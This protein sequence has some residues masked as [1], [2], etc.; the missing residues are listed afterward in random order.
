MRQ[1]LHGQVG[2]G[3]MIMSG[4][5]P[6][7]GLQDSRE[8]AVLKGLISG[9]KDKVGLVLCPPYLTQTGYYAAALPVDNVFTSSCL[10]S[11]KH[12]CEQSLMFKLHYSRRQ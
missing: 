11:F 5:I 9:D 3:S 12:S 2:Y 6:D 7:T 8:E 1:L 10:I 4:E